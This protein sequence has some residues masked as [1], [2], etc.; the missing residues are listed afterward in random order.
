MSN[1]DL[2]IDGTG[3]DT[4]A[5]VREIT[6]RELARIRPLP[7]IIDIREEAEF[8]RG[9]ID[10]ARQISRATL[11]RRI[12]EIAPDPTTPIVVYCAVGNRGSLAA[13]QL[14]RLGYRKAFSLKGGLQRWLEAGGMVEVQRAVPSREFGD[15]RTLAAFSY[16]FVTRTRN[17]VLTQRGAD[18]VDRAL[19]LWDQAQR[20]LRERLGEQGWSTM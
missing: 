7:V 18:R 9:H 10:G 15:G 5:S 12:R 20:K 16:S 13:E 4:P 17:V 19:P 1:Y 8:M 3:N 14:Q 2:P 6:P 11:E